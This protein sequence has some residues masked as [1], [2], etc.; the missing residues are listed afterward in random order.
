MGPAQR[1]HQPAL[2]RAPGVHEN[3]RLTALFADNLCRY[4]AGQPLRNVLDKDLLY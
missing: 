2:G 1:H 4:L 3:E